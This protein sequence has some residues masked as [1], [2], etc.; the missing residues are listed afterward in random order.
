MDV[1]NQ[2]L[3]KPF[4]LTPHK[5][6]HK[7]TMLLFKTQTPHKTFWKSYILQ[8]HNVFLRNPKTPQTHNVF[9]ENLTPY[10]LTIIW[11]QSQSFKFIKHISNTQ[12][13][14]I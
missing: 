14:Q 5:N 13:A 11:I 9:F 3:K 2:S 8:I 12:I 10:K 7:P 4:A 1:P 6:P